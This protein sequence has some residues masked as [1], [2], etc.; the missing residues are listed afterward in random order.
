MR[1]A[2]GSDSRPAQEGTSLPCLSSTLLEEHVP[3]QTDL[4]SK[5]KS[6]AFAG[7]IIIARIPR[8]P[9]GRGPGAPPAVFA[10]SPVHANRDR[11]L[12]MQPLSP[13]R[14]ILVG[15]SGTGCDQGI[16]IDYLSIIID[17]GPSCP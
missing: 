2:S 14:R 9:R 10:W 8:N 13:G 4:F 11:T 5:P 16:R 6:F 3:V 17:P 1:R 15:R 12:A 7:K